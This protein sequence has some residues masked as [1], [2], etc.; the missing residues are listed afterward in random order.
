LFANNDDDEEIAVE[1][2][3]AGADAAA[4][5]MD[6]PV[7]R[8]DVHRVLAFF[9]EIEPEPEDVDSA[10]EYAALMDQYRDQIE[11]G[12]LTLRAYGEQ[13][14]IKTL[15]NMQE[16]YYSFTNDPRY[17]D[18]ALWVYVVTSV[19]SEAWHGVGPWRR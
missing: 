9:I 5:A 14:K 13:I 15:S 17:L 4:I 6:G 16:V 1:E 3:T 18:R 10:E 7:A 2:G 11:A 12:K 19:L 8:S